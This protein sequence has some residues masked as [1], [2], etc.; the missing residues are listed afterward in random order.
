M[1]ENHRNAKSGSGTNIITLF[2]DMRKA[3]LLLDPKKPVYVSDEDAVMIMHIRAL[4][5]GYD[6]FI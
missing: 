1:R 3:S 6:C 4:I 2:R 5:G